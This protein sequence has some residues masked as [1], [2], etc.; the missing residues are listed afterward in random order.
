MP[1]KLVV[2]VVL[3]SVNL[4]VSLGQVAM[5][6][7]GLN[8][9]GLLLNA[10][11]LW[12]VLSGKEGV[13]AFLIGASWIGLFFSLFGLVGAFLMMST[14]I[15]AIAGLI[16]LVSVTIGIVR[17]G[18]TIWCLNQPEVQSWMFKKSTGQV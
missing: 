7:V 4:L 17:C 2:L 16:T 15:G 13:R 10:F 6:G 14:L 18:Y 11:L 3:L 5:D 1:S 8:I 9:V 12:G